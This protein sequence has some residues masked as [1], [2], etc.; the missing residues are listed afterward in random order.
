M[1]DPP[2]DQSN[3]FLSKSQVNIP[4][5]L[6]PCYLEKHEILTIRDTFTSALAIQYIAK[7]QIL[8]GQ[9]S[10]KSYRDQSTLLS[11]AN[12]FRWMQFYP[13]TNCVPYVNIFIANITLNKL[14]IT[15]KA[16]FQEILAIL[17]IEQVSFPKWTFIQK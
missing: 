14:R 7:W 13:M 3:N 8:K 4:Q 12:Q 16:D 9:H 2:K 1:I 17:Q 10:D 6:S 15:C 5:W 11:M